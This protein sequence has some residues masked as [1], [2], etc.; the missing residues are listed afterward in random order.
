MIYSVFSYKMLK[1]F[2][3]RSTK[4]LLAIMLDAFV[5]NSGNKLKC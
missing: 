2:K 3:G 5:L 4:V 1:Y